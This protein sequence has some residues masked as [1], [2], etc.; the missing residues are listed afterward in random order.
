MREMCSLVQFVSNWNVFS[1]VKKIVMF[2]FVSIP[3]NTKVYQLK[4]LQLYLSNALSLSN[5]YNPHD[6][7]GLCIVP[8]LVPD[9]QLIK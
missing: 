8:G 5:W 1:G 7:L 9:G 3:D 2:Q 4:P 6:E